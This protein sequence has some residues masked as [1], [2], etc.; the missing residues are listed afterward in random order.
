MKKIFRNNHI[1]FRIFYHAAK[2]YRM[3]QDEEDEGDDQRLDE[4]SSE[5]GEGVLAPHKVARTSDSPRFRR[6]DSTGADIEVRKAM[7]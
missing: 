4:E 5:G 6:T 2:H 7:V 3:S 1:E